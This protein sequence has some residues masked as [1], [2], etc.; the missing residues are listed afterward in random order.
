VIPERRE[1]DPRAEALR[2]RHSALFG[3]AELPVPVESIAADLL[4]LHVE[5][6]E[7]LEVSGMLVA[8][9][10]T[11]RLNAGEARDSPGRRRFTLA[12]EIAHWVCHCPPNRPV[13]LILC[14]PAQVGVSSGDAMERE[15]NV[16]AAELLMPASEVAA[17]AAS[18]VGVAEIA[19]RFGV[20]DVALAWRL[21]NLGLAERPP[22]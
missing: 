13:Q 21:F 7:G 17:A 3:G 9:E 22:A 18:G 19:A 16:F 12:H 10:R 4:G 8:A 20:S 2:A 5:E 1:G 15:A 6:R 14:R 11:I